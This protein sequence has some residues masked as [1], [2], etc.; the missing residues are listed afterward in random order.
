[1]KPFMKRFVASL[2]VSATVL[3]AVHA[4]LGGAQGQN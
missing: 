1:M 3:P 2:I 4:R